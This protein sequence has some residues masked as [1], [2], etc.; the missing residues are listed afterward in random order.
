MAIHNEATTGLNDW[1]RML[2]PSTTMHGGSG[3]GNTGTKRKRSEAL[4]LA[5]DE[6]EDREH[7]YRPTGLAPSGQSD[8]TLTGTVG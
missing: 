7:E 1:S 6:N 8:L 2:H 3:A 5:L 4:D